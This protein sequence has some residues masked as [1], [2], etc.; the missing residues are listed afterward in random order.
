[1][2]LA[3]H[4]NDLIVVHDAS[5]SHLRL[6]DFRAVHEMLRR[7]D[8]GEILNRCFTV[9]DRSKAPRATLIRSIAFFFG[10]S[11]SNCHCLRFL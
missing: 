6:F 8:R 3:L 7:I 2:H 5:L 10:K 9:S 4:Y 11:H 1:M